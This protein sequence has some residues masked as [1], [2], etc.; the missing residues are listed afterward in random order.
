MC[1]L[2]INLDPAHIRPDAKQAIKR[3]QNTKSGDQAADEL[4]SRVRPQASGRLSSVEEY[5][6]LKRFINKEGLLAQRSS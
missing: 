2:R 3:R 4:H 6:D 5:A 1:L